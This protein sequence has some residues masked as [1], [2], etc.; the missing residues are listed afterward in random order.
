MSALQLPLGA[1][2]KYDGQRRAFLWLGED[3][4]SG[5][6]CLVAWDAVTRPLEQGGGGLVS[7]ILQSRT[8]VCY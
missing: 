4:V 8:T 5:A 6:Q 2:D 3:T 1:I 7:V